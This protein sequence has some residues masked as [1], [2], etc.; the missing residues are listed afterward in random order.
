MAHK[1]YYCSSS[2]KSSL[3]AQVQVTSDTE[4]EE[5]VAGPAPKV[6]VEAGSPT[7]PGPSKIPASS[8]GQ[9]SPSHSHNDHVIKELKLVKPQDLMPEPS[10][11]IIISGL[12]GNHF[13]CDGC[14]IK[15]KSVSNLQAHQARYCAGLRKSE[16][17][18]PVEAAGAKRHHQPK[19]SRISPMQLPP[20]MTAADMINFLS[21]K[22][23][24]QQLA[25]AAAAQA[26][27]A[28]AITK[29]KPT[30]HSMVAM[31]SALAGSSTGKS[32]LIVMAIRTSPVRLPSNS[33]QLCNGPGL[34]PMKKLLRRLF[35]YPEIN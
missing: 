16:D 34:N 4:E 1:K 17:L 27:A 15:F 2:A 22:S 32:L 20:P 9:A 14:G 31:A 3:P 10:A 8:T 6:K 7:P 18:A 13:I 21:A 23:I 19:P 30:H 35:L 26:A 25:V 11:G 33:R 29:D 5:P 28:L 24:E 12:A